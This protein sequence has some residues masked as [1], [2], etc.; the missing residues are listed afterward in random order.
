MIWRRI[1]Q[2][3]RINKLSIKFHKVI[4]HSGI[5]YN[6]MTVNLAKLGLELPVG[7][8]SKFIQD[9]IIMTPL[10]DSFSKHILLIPYYIIHDYKILSKITPSTTYIGLNADMDQL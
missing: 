3:Y 7:I 10:W 1:K 8:N 6:D 5:E 4:A 9:A 2:I